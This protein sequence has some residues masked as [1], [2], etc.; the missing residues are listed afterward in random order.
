[1]VFTG[2][3]KL[4][5]LSFFITKTFFQMVKPGGQN[6]RGQFGAWPLMKLL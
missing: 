2:G 1:M 3:A 5:E 6:H 4:F